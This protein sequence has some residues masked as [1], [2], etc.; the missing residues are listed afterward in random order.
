MERITHLT[1]EFV[2]SFPAKLE[3]GKVY[4]SIK[5]AT[6]TH[7][8]CCGCGNQVVTPISRVAWKL[9]FDGESISLDPSI[10]NWSFPCKSHYWITRNHVRWAEVWS[11]EEISELRQ[12]KTQLRESHYAG[13]APRKL[14][15]SSPKEKKKENGKGSFLQKLKSWVT[16][17]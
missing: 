14:T 12:N 10:G 16:P 3:D 13:K 5:F 8:C 2:E 7:K 1:H 15:A 11:R 17:K 6:S 4:V 9:I